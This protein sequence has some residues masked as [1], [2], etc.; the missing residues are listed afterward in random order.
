MVLGHA[1]PFRVIRTYPIGI[2]RVSSITRLKVLNE[3][4]NQ[5]LESN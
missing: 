5:F 2:V 4:P 3:M 1:I